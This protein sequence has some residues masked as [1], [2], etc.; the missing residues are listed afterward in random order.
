MGNKTLTVPKRI[1]GIRIPKQVRKGPF[2]SLLSTP[3]GQILLAELLIV[4]G[5]AIAT[6]VN[7][8][9]KTGKAL[10][11]ALSEGLQELQGSGH[12]KHRRRNIGHSLG[13][14]FARGYDAFRQ[15]MG[16]ESSDSASEETVSRGKKKNSK[17]T[18]SSTVRH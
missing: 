18:P 14:G 2:G 4:I 17:P 16:E 15:A 11:V 10:R 9:T 5:G 7:P 3:A 12:K 1:A 13:S 8:D 6:A